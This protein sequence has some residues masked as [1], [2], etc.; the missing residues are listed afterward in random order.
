MTRTVLYLVSKADA[1]AEPLPD[2]PGKI[3]GLYFLEWL[4]NRQN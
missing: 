4:R 3:V 2:V 1:L